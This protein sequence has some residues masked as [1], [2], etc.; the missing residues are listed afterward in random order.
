MRALLTRLA[1]RKNY[2]I[3]G[4]ILSLRL[5]VA[6]YLKLVKSASPPMG[7]LQKPLSMDAGRKLYESNCAVCH[8]TG[9]FGAPQINKQGICQILRGQGREHLYQIVIKGEGSMLSKGDCDTC[10]DVR[11]CVLGSFKDI[12]N[13]GL[14][15][16]VMVGE[17]VF[18]VKG[19]STS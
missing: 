2:K 14:S 5:A 12:L 8:D 19:D 18:A 7:D 3:Q 17:I 16:R 9:I 10:S 1:G 11:A 15:F 6:D 13:L 4:C